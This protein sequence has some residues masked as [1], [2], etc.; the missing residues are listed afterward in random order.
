M[1]C[2]SCGPRAFQLCFASSSNSARFLL[3]SIQSCSFHPF[4]V[5]VSVGCWELMIACVCMLAI[6]IFPKDSVWGSN[7]EHHRFLASALHFQM[8]LVLLRISRFLEKPLR[9]ETASRFA[10]VVFYCLRRRSLGFISEYLDQTAHVDQ[11]TFG[12]FM[13]CNLLVRCSCLTLER[14]YRSNQVVCDVMCQA[15]S[16]GVCPPH[17]CRN[18]EKDV[19]RLPAL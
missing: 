18:R 5:G 14:G 6:M 16:C 12:K 8:I 9:E 19:W 13:V 4:Q 7:S 3:F 10:S 1:F 17:H 2:R 15:I 11:R